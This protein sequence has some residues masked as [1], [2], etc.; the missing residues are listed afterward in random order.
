MALARNSGAAQAFECRILPKQERLMNFIRQQL[1]L[2]G[3][4][5][6]KSQAWEWQ[7]SGYCVR[8]TKVYLGDKERIEEQFHEHVLLLYRFNVKY[9]T[10]F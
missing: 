1:T 6:N 10:I 2:T 8:S 5:G 3:G 4:E 9:L 7:L